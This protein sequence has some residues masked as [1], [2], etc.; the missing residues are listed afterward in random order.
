MLTYDERH[1]ATYLLWI[2]EGIL[3]YQRSCV[4][5][6]AKG[7]RPTMLCNP[8]LLLYYCITTYTVHRSQYVGI[9]V[10]WQKSALCVY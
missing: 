8:V 4:M 7:H 1:A 5:I 3:I 2:L 6:K 9:S 10:A